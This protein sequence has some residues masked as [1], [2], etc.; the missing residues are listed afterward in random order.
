MDCCRLASR[1]YPQLFTHR[2]PPEIKRVFEE[3]EQFPRPLWGE[4]GSTARGA[5]WAQT[6][7]PDLWVANY[8]SPPQ[9][10]ERIKFCDPGGG[11]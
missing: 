1:V 6:P 8:Y 11:R 10:G 9:S 5:R 4:P 7:P 3:F 2:P